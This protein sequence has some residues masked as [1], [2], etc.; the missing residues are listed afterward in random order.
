VLTEALGLS[1]AEAAAVC[2]CP[3]GTIR[4]RMARA[5]DL[6]GMLADVEREPRDA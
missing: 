6:I 4:S 3:V 1:Y 2:R 5:R